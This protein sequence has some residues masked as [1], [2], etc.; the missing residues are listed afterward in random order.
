MTAAENLIS[1]L[2]TSLIPH[3]SNVQFLHIRQDYLAA[4]NGA[5][6]PAVILDR[7]DKWTVAD[8]VP[9]G[10][11][12]VDSW[13]ILTQAQLV[14]GLL[15]CFGV[16]NVRAAVQFL[17]D[18]GLIELRAMPNPRDRKSQYRLHVE[19]L[20][21]V[22]ER[23]FTA[24]LSIGQKGTMES[25]DL[26][27]PTNLDETQESPAPSTAPTPKAAS[28]I[29]PIRLMQSADLPNALGK[30]AQC[31]SNDLDSSDLDHVS[32]G[33]VQI[34]DYR[35]SMGFVVDVI[36]C[37]LFPVIWKAPAPMIAGG[38]PYQWGKQRLNRPGIHRAS[39]YA[40]GIATGFGMTAVQGDP[41]V[42]VDI[43]QPLFEQQLLRLIPR[44]RMTYRQQ[45]GNHSCLALRL[46]RLLDKRI[47]VSNA[48]GEVVSIRGFG[49]YQVGPGSLH[50]SGDRYQANMLPPLTLTDTETN[51]LMALIELRQQSAKPIIASRRE[52]IEGIHNTAYRFPPARLERRLESWAKKSIHELVRD[53]GTVSVDFNKSLYRAACRSAGLARYSGHA[54]ADLFQ[55]LLT[56]ADVAGY[57]A[58]DGQRQAEGTIRSGLA[59]GRD[60]K[61]IWLPDWAEKAISAASATK[62]A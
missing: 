16:K 48:D 52:Q 15:D 30:K 31:I 45:R 57:I 53:L 1:D 7:L 27:N 46:P 23:A 61:K 58:R 47:E 19:R 55:M 41:L 10:I 25:A 56:Q 24:A 17:V 28:P 51:A 60:L 4:C 59:D 40:W 39:K 29:V 32:H 44:L 50:Q 13:L 35:D 36:R 34:V 5:L 11:E 62:G 18:K 54:D 2:Q 42:F 33:L 9:E 38:A 3:S 21:S 37:E 12:R 20:R 22:I 6:C 43:D 14:A 8:S 26:P 49:S